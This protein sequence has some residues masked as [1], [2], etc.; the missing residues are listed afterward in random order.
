MRPWRAYAIA[1][2]T[3]L[4][5]TTRCSS[6]TAAAAAADNIATI[7]DRSEQSSGRTEATAAETTKACSFGTESAGRGLEFLFA[8]DLVL[9]ADLKNIPTKDVMLESTARTTIT[10]ENPSMEN[11]AICCKSG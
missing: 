10:M 7:F 4:K 5:E 2:G 3:R 6:S 9:S 11:T 8:A 1:S